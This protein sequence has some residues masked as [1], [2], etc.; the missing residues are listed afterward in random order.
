MLKGLQKTC[1]H[2]FISKIFINIINTG[3]ANAH[4]WRNLI[5]FN[6]QFRG[7]RRA[8]N[9]STP[10]MSIKM[11]CCSLKLLLM[12]GIYVKIFV[13]FN[14]LVDFII[15]LAFNLLYTHKHNDTHTHTRARSIVFNNVTTKRTMMIKGIWMV[16]WWYIHFLFVGFSLLLLPI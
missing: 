3:K 7:P 16:W 8:L 13:Y 1:A 14:P 12:E 11:W 6:K 4:G 10:T 9:E 2:I 15:I 5:N